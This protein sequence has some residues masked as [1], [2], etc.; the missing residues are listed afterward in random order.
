MRSGRFLASIR[1]LLSER[2]MSKNKRTRKR[3]DGLD[4]RIRQHEEKI[5]E[6]KVRGN[7][8]LGTIRHW[9]IEIRTW[10][11]DVERLKKR[12]PGRK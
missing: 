12:L 7:P 5:A 10:R 11:N 4:R 9:E 1:S 6:E 8:D 3:I 2:R